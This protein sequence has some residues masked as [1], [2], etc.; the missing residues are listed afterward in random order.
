MLIQTDLP[1]DDLDPQER[2]IVD[3]SKLQKYRNDRLRYN[4]R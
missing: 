3:K 1:S 4:A 2:I